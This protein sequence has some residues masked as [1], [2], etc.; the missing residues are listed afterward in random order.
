MCVFI[1]QQNIYRRTYKTASR[2]TGWDGIVVPLD[3]YVQQ[4]SYNTVI[5]LNLFEVVKWNKWRRGLFEN[6]CVFIYQQNIYR[7]TARPD[8]YDVS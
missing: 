3:G 6:M 1:Y 4:N 2:P 8:G 7:R 5:R